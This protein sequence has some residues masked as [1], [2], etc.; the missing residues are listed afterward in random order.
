MMKETTALSE[1][2]KSNNNETIKDVERFA[3]DT[4][5]ELALTN[6]RMDTMSEKIDTMDERMQTAEKLLDLNKKVAD[7]RETVSQKELNDSSLFL[8]LN[9][10]EMSKPAKDL[11]LQN[12]TNDRKVVENALE[13]SLGTETAGFVLKKA[14]DGGLLNILNLNTPPY[15]RRN[16]SDKVPEICKNTLIFKFR[17]RAQLAHFEKAIR[18]RLFLSRDERKESN[19]EF[20]DLNVHL[21]G[22]AGQLLKSLLNA[23]AKVTVGSSESLSGWRLVWRRQMESSY[24]MML[25]AEVR[26]AKSWMDS[27][28]RDFFYDGN[29]HQVRGQWTFL[30]NVDSFNPKRSFFPRLKFRATEE[31]QNRTGRTTSSEV[32]TTEE[33]EGVN[34]E[35]NRTSE[36]ETGARARKP[37][38][39]S[40]SPRVEITDIQ[41]EEE[42]GGEWNTAGRG[43][44][45][46]GGNGGGARGGRGGDRGGRRGRSGRGD[47]SQSSIQQYMDPSTP[48]SRLATGATGGSSWVNI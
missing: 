3:K 29:G 2:V 38:T 13:K 42:E 34:G 10:I 48:K 6:D 25:F 19:A 9:G 35:R 24:D 46:R 26:A 18:K 45:G 32:T 16:Y 27:E 41:N 20:L 28:M 33:G 17:N 4:K 31:T 37:G 30:R 7:C 43:K 1:L 11:D 22:R 8:A 12:N 40:K 21:P 47:S 39:R 23:Q 36:R 15:Q 44:N 14:P 5:T